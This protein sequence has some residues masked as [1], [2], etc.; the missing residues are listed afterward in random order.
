MFL[1]W[2]R[3]YYIYRPADKFQSSLLRCSYCDSLTKKPIDLSIT[4]QSSLLRCS[5]CDAIHHR[6]RIVHRLVSILF[7][8]VFLLWRHQSAPRNDSRVL[9]VSILF[10]EVFLLWLPTGITPCEIWKE[11][12]SSLLRCSYCD[13][14]LPWFSSGSHMCFNPLYWGVLI[15]TIRR[16]DRRTGDDVS[17]LFTEVFLLWPRPRFRSL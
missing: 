5:Y 12:Q 4:F 16:G 7:T 2:H 14:L 8:E 13:G 3:L 17:I 1:L 9:C 11:F 6:G 15:V 10:T